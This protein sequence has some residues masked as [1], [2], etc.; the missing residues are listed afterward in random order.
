MASDDELKM[1]LEKF[2]ESLHHAQVGMNALLDSDVEQISQLAAFAEGLLDYHRQCVGILETLAE[3]LE[4]SKEEAKR[5]PK[6]EIPIKPM[7]DL[8]LSIPDSNSDGSPMNT[9]SPARS[10]MNQNGPCCTALYD[11]DPENPGELGFKNWYEGSVR[12]QKGLFPVTYVQIVVPL[13]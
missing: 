12:G 8:H 11:F 6:K 1:A 9:A 13:P 10:P 3:K 4:T 2:G 7:T 5:Q